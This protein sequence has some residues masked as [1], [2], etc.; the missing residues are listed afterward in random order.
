VYFVGCGGS[1]V[2]LGAFRPEGR[3][4]KSHSIRYVGTLSP[5]ITCYHPFIQ[6]LCL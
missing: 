5:V 2:G 4:F 1:V 3:R 6:G